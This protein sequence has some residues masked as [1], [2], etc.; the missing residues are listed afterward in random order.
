MDDAMRVS[1]LCRFSANDIPLWIVIRSGDRTHFSTRSWP[2]RTP[3]QSHGENRRPP[4]ENDRRTCGQVEKHLGNEDWRV[5][6]DR[7]NVKFCN[8][9]FNGFNLTWN[10]RR[11]TER[12]ARTVGPLHDQGVIN[13]FWTSTFQSREIPWSAS[14]H[15]Y[16]IA[17]SRSLHYCFVTKCRERNKNSSKRLIILGGD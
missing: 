4:G 11:S 2:M 7:S 16:P 1:R 8:F 10:S 9:N 14:N 5:E 12:S 6:N 17:R 15:V 3:F 13:A